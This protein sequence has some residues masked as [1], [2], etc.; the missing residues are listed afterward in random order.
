MNVNYLLSSRLVR[1]LPPVALLGACLWALFT[2]SRYSPGWQPLLIEVMPLTTL[3]VAMLLSIRF[4]RSR[5]SFLLLFLGLAWAVQSPLRGQLLPATESLLF[6]LLFVNAFVFSLLKDR[7]LFSVHGLL[8]GGFLLLQAGT[9]WLLVTQTPTVPAALLQHEWFSLPESIA[10]FVQLPDGIVVVSIA[11]TLAHLG[12]SLIRNSSIQATFFGCQLG[13][14]G[15]ASG[16]PDPAFV[17]FL[18]TGCGLIVTLSIILDS[19]DMAYRDEL[20]G[21]PSR[22]ALNQA[23]L[24]LG[25][26]YTVAMLDIDHFKKFNDTHGHDVG[27]EV[28]QMVASKIARIGG[29][30]K[31]FRYGGEE[32]TILFPRKT[33]EQAQAHLEALRA[34]IEKYRMVVRKNVRN[35]GKDSGKRARVRRGK[36]DPRHKALSVTISIGFAERNEDTKMPEAVIKAADEALYRAKQKGRNCL[37]E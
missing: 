20:T 15:I 5:Y 33:P 18:V 30:G 21:L 3:A 8:R 25:R 12:L 24:S 26:R 1:P 14:L 17:P 10:I 4:N 35:S 36:N 16:Y 27:D 9:T 19:H 23:L 28:L 32:F 13:L 6:A 37:S 2:V 7:S 29:G 22:R 34:T 11:I 31:P